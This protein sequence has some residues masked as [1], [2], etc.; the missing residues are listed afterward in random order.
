MATEHVR[1]SLG[2]AQAPE[3]RSGRVTGENSLVFPAASKPSM[4]RRISLDPKIL[5]MIFE[6][7][8]PMIVMLV[9][10]DYSDSSLLVQMIMV[11]G[12][13][14]CDANRRTD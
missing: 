14:G 1:I 8:P 3:C 13:D 4:S 9:P 5:P 11:S 6:T 12:C 10:Y 2:F 7:E